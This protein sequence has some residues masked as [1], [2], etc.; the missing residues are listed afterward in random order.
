[1]NTANTG[2]QR[3]SLLNNTIMLTLLTGS[4][5]VFG[6]MSVP[7]L[8]RVLGPETY[9]FIGLGNAFYTIVQL[10][11]DF[12]FLLSGTLEIAKCDGDHERIQRV[13][14]AVIVAKAFLVFPVF[15]VTLVIVCSVSRFSNDIL[16]YLLYFAYAA[17][18]VLVPDF[19]Y[20]G[21][22]N[23][24][25]VTIRNVIVKTVFVSLIFLFVKEPSQYH[26]VP[27]FY[28]CGSLVSTV[29]MYEHVHR[30]LRINFVRVSWHEVFVQLKK[31][32]LYFLSR[33]ASTVF[34]SVNTIVMGFIAPTGP[35]VGCYSATNTTINAGRQ[36]VTP[37]TDSLFPN[38]VRTKNYRLMYKVAIFGSVLL[39]CGCIVVGVFAKPLCLFAFGEGYDDMV[40]M[41]RIML[42]LIPIALLSYLFGWSGLGSI[43]KDAMTN[44][45]VVVGAVVHII[46]LAALFVMGQLS[47]LMLCA[48]SVATQFTILV[49]RVF[50]FFNGVKTQ[51]SFREASNE[52]L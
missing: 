12:G 43:G 48:T 42:P 38:I 31:S 46:L 23:M 7:Y 50:T 52:M 20:R 1:M 27:I 32:S 36:I 4:N 2:F 39:A 9:G 28:A 13:F 34:T 35:T 21:L 6:L 51:S 33:V 40:P 45:S 17:C 44:I 16:L 29:T 30:V 19:L 25:S 37:V 14:S 3:K 15:C 24:V 49:I 18:N 10:V 8:T 11:L 5:Y 22:E 26:L 41:L 47:P